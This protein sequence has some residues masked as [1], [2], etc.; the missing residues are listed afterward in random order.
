MHLREILKLKRLIQ[1]KGIT[2]IPLSLYLKRGKVKVK[3]ASARG[4]KL[5][6]KREKIKEKEHKKKIDRAIKAER[7]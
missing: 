2:L 7:Y 5:F 3:I 4:K 6:D 1:E